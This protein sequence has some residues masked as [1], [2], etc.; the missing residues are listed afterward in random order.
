MPLTNITLPI[1]G[2]GEIDL[3]QAATALGALPGV[4]RVYLSRAVEMAYVEYDPTR[5]GV[6]QLSAALGAARALSND[7][8]AHAIR[9]TDIASA[10]PTRFALARMIVRVLAAASFR[11]PGR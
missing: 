1:D 9:E 5:C 8:S 10:E 6:D 4:T 3:S 11:H 2:V 7:E